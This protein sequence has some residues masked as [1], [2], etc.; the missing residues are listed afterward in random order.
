MKRLAL[1]L[2]VLLVLMTSCAATLRVSGTTPQQV[3]DGSCAAPVLL[4]AS[5]GAAWMVHA[6][7]LGR[8]LEDSV[9]VAPGDGFAFSWTLPAGSY[10][11]RAW[12]SLA[13]APQY[14]GCDT[15]A[16]FDALAAPW[17]PLLGK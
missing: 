2:L 1:G 3:N 13:R 11:V 8:G 6:Q 5:A 4:P 12:V 15:T 14:A 7:V 9:A 17:K 16:T 10:Q